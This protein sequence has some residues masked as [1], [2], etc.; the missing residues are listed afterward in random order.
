MPALT[1]DTA[2]IRYAVAYAIEIY[3]ELTEENGARASAHKTRWWTFILADPELRA[4]AAHWGA[5]IEV[6]KPRLRPR[7]GCRAT[8]PIVASGLFSNRSW[9]S[10]FL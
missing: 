5:L 6:T 8:P 2:L 3:R 7:G 9:M 10:R 1:E 4:A